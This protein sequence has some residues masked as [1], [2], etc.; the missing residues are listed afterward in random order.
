LIRAADARPS[1]FSGC[2][3]TAEF[4]I[5]L[6]TQTHH[7]RWQSASSHSSLLSSPCAMSTKKASFEL[8]EAL[9]NRFRC[10]KLLSP[11]V[12]ETRYD[13]VGTE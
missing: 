9:G 2:P 6:Q 5:R 3:Q 7:V 11:L 1:G 13:I 4:D 10:W 12:D 8:V